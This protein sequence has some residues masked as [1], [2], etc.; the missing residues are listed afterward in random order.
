MS[1]SEVGVLKAAVLSVFTI[2]FLSACPSCDTVY[3]DTDDITVTSDLS[4]IDD[5]NDA[6]LLDVYEPV[7]AAAD[8]T[9][10]LFFH[11]GYWIGQDKDYYEFALGLYG[12][13][14]VA[15]ARRGFRVAN[16]NYR[17]HP[18]TDV[19][20]MM[21]DVDAAAALMR[22]R[23][24]GARIVLMGHSAGAHLASAAALLPTGPRTPV[25]GLVLLSGILDI[26]TAIENDTEENVTE[27][28]IPVFGSTPE[29][30]AAGST[31]DDVIVSTVPT[32]LMTASA[33][34][35]H[36]LKDADVVKAAATPLVTFAQVP[37]SGHADMVLQIG[38]DA[39]AVTPAVVTFLSTLP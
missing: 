8:A 18:T 9:V 11:G 17:L 31:R 4:Y 14:G 10:V 27:A 36:V 28:L 33:D 2:V 29:A 3:G 39:D 26:E 38:S 21:Q 7:D 15:L 20:G 35:P 25:D 19:A 23:H 5:G 22:Q 6:H 12:N 32:L 16:A 1:T 34:Y 24:P 13:V 37:E 30:R